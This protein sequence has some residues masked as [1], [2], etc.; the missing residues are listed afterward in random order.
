MSAFDEEKESM[1]S[2]NITC[3]VS[4]SKDAL[5][6]HVYAGGTKAVSMNEH[7]MFINTRISRTMGVG[8]SEVDDVLTLGVGNTFMVTGVSD[9]KWIAT[10]DWNPGANIV[11][12][13]VNSFIYRHNAADSPA[14]TAP[15]KLNGSV[16]F[17]ATADSTLS[18]AYNGSYWF[19][20]GR[21]I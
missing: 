10:A 3:G 20:T 4:Q 15:L 12:I 7:M 8:V 5:T 19:E 17:E 13:M 18:L 21:K 16:D 1:I 11:L 14:G 6:L 9:V 2:G